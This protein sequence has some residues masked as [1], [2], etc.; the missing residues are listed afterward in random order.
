MT[1]ALREPLPVL[2]LALTRHFSC[3]GGISRGQQALQLTPVRSTNGST[4]HVISHI[5]PAAGLASE[6]RCGRLPGSGL[7]RTCRTAG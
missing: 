3:S 6:T 5:P 1:Y 2:T 7:L 4:P